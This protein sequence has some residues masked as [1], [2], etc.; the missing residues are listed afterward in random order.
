MKAAV[1]CNGPSRNL[2]NSTD[3]YNYIIGCNVPWTKVD[4]TVVVDEIVVERW[5]R[6][7]ELITVPAYFSRKA[8][9]YTDSIKKR[10]FF[11]QYFIDIIDILPDFDSSGHNAAK[12][13]IKKGATTL[14][15]YGCD[16]WF[17]QT[18]VS[19]THKYFKNLNPDDSKKHVIGWRKRWQEIMDGSPHVQFNFIRKEK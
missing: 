15:I 5:A 18:I 16:S 2:F 19:H 6:E 9:M 3:G 17:E 1:L 14:D 4:A 12:C 8:W 13:A 7:P 10:S 11:E